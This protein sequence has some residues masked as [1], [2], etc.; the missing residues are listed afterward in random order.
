M[1]QTLS[2]LADVAVLLARCSGCGEL[3]PPTSR[4]ER[5]PTAHSEWIVAECLKCRV[6][7]P[8]RLEGK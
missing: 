2:T 4:V 5:Y 3:L 6:V 8:F 1:T 7:T